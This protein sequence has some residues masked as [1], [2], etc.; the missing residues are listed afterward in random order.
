MVPRLR[1]IRNRVRQRRHP[2][3]QRRR[4]VRMRLTVLCGGLLLAS[5]AVLLAVTYTLVVGA[6]PLAA[7]F[8]RS[9]RG[10]SAV[11]SPGPDLAGLAQAA[12]ERNADLHHLLAE[13][14]VTLAVLAVVSAGAGWLVAGRLLRPLRKITAAARDISASNLHARLAMHGPDDELKELGDTFDSLLSRLDSAFRS[15]RQFIANASHELRTPLTLER[16][17]LEAALADPGPTT[18]TWR[19]ACERALAAAQR[20]ERLIDALLTLT[21][22]EAGI[23]RHEPLDLADL[24]GQVLTAHQAAAQAQ[25]LPLSASLGAAPA[26]GNPSLIERL[27]TNLVDN[28]IRHNIRHGQVVVTTGTSHG[29][30]TLCVLNTGPVVPATETGRI[31]Q[32]FHQ[33]DADR[34]RP[35]GGFGLGLSIVQA[36]AAA[37]TADIAVRA[38]PEGG[39]EITVSFPEPHPSRRRG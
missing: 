24:A 26:R 15:Q 32:P 7:T 22:S 13:Y 3:R 30:A 16:I 39:L 14:A 5:G 31:L 38:R 37:H 17:L 27:I 36:I 18:D 25:G 28:A 35:S 2:A 33:L 29:H 23:G 19:S 21:R 1:T 11:S 20:Q 12:R 9:A 6:F 4:T 10:P 8:K 34:S